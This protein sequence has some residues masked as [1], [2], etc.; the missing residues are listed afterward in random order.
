MLRD[1]FASVPR[2]C[3]GVTLGLAVLVTYMGILQLL[4][5]RR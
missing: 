5:F 3:S 4:R 1:V 2:S